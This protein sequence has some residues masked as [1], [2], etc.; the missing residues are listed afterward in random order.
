MRLSLDFR[1]EL[2]GVSTW[3]V[4]QFDRLIAQIKGSWNVEHNEDGHHTDITATTV[5]TTG[6]VTIGG[7]L[8]GSSSAKFTGDVVA[9]Q[10]TGRECGLGILAVVNG[11]TFLA[12]EATRWG[13]LIAG[14]A[15]GHFIEH[16][17]AQSPFLGGN[18]LAFW[19]LANSTSK[20]AFR[21][22]V[23]AGVPTLLDGGTGVS[24]AI[25]DSTDPIAAIHATQ[26]LS[27]GR[28]TADGEWTSVAFNAANFTA[29]VGAWTVIAGNQ[30]DFRYSFNGKT[31]TVTFQFDATTTT[32]VTQ[33]LRIAIPNG[34]LATVSNWSTTVLCNSGGPWAHGNIFTQAGAGFIFIQPD[35]LG[36]G[37]FPVS[38]G[39]VYVRG[40]ISF[41]V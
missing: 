28:L 41:E 26:F 30:I 21:V 39:G 14:I 36:A 22:G 29:A 37:T 17:S 13:A 16:R 2:S 34:M 40:T 31:M 6:A 11:T 7:A 20:P 12:A 3:I 15:A 23:L 19:N 33:N 5:T 1:T 18:E 8:T 24:L 25:G 27:Q 32:G 9:L 4:E 10:A 38:A 35:A